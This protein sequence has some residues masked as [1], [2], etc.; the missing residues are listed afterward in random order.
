M[1]APPPDDRFDIWDP[2]NVSPLVAY[3]AAADCPITGKVFAVQ[4]GSIQ[5]LSGWSVASQIETV[6]PWRIDDIAARL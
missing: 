3:L 2:A 1:V 6:G 5:E 4:G